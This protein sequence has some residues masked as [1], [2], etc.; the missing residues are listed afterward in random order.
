MDSAFDHKLVE[1]VAGDLECSRT[2]L[3]QPAGFVG[4][5]VFYAL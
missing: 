2:S 1:R 3:L 4:W 5:S